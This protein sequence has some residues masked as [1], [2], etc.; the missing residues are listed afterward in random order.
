VASGQGLEAFLEGNFRAVLHTVLAE[1]LEQEVREAN[2]SRAEY[3]AGLEGRLLEP[4]RAL[5]GQRLQ[6]LFAE[7]G[8]LELRPHVPDLESTLAKVAISVTDTVETPLAAKGTGVRG[9]LLVALLSYLADHARRGLVFLIEEPEAFLHPAAQEDLRDTL[10]T[11]AARPDVTTVVTTHSPFIVPRTPEGQVLAL[12]KDP[13]GRT[14][15]EA[16]SS[17]GAEH[18][19]LVGGLLRPSTFERVLRSA[20]AVSPDARGVLLVEGEGDRFCLELAAQRAGRRELVADL[21]IRPTGGTS[22][23]VVQAVVARAALHDSGIGLAILLDADEEGKEAARTL[24]SSKFRFQGQQIL[25]YADVLR[26]DKQDQFPYEAEDLWPTELMQDFVD[27]H[28]WEAQRRRPDGGLHYD[29]DQCAKQRLSE[30]LHDRVRHEHTDRW[31]ELLELVRRGLGLDVPAP[32]GAGDGADAVGPSAADDPSCASVLVLPGSSPLDEYRRWGII[33]LPPDVDL[34]DQLGHVAFYHEGQIRPVVPAVREVFRNL[35]FGRAV[36]EHLRRS[37]DGPERV[38][39]LILEQ[40]DLGLV[41]PGEIHHAV[42]LS[43]RDA[44]DAVRLDGP[45]RNTK[46]IRGNRTVAWILGPTSVPL[47]AL[48]AGPSTTSELDELISSAEGP[49]G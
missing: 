7:I 13:E 14:R 32:A 42:V 40:L 49:P 35:T 30:F 39:Q 22:L 5:L 29:I 48:R 19:H 24:K 47:Q 16:T 23:M 9:G 44:A 4:L 43:P 27:L 8:S 15:V 31:V 34:P 45:V 38:A 11:L 18:A 28:G 36:A 1:Q 10:E 46:T 21:D 2:R 41:Q 20:F 37:G 6:D 3:V 25:S 33:T 17:G 26:V 12:A